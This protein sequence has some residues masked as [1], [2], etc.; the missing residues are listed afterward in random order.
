MPA[1]CKTSELVGG[2]RGEIAGGGLR[3]TI[4]PAGAVVSFGAPD[5]GLLTAAEIGA[6]GVGSRN[7][8]GELILRWRAAAD[9]LIIVEY[10]DRVIEKVERRLR[11][12]CL[13]GTATTV[14]GRDDCLTVSTEA[15]VAAAI[16]LTAAVIRERW[17]DE[18]AATIAYSRCRHFQAVIALAWGGTS[19]AAREILRGAVTVGG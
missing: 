6:D 10:A 18:H 14:I 7:A 9:D 2:C 4:A 16:C 3:V 19:T 5:A 12:A 11:L 15:G 1:E 8:R 13:D 17:R